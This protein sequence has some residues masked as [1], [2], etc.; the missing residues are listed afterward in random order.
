MLLCKIPMQCDVVADPVKQQPAE[1]KS[2]SKLHRMMHREIAI[3]RKS[4][5]GDQIRSL[6]VGQTE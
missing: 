1:L 2:S 5:S 3:A 6:R 4:G